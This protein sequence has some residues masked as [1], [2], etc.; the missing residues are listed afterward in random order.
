MK[1]SVWWIMSV[2]GVGAV[3]VLLPATVAAQQSIWTSSYGPN[4]FTVEWLRPEFS[5]EAD[6]SFLTSVTYLSGRAMVAKNLRLV[7]EIPLVY[8]DSEDDDA[9]L[10]VGNPYLGLE[11]GNLDTVW[12][13]V[14][15]RVPVVAND[16]FTTFFLGFLTDFDRLEAFVPEVLSVVALGNY[17]WQ[18]RSGFSARLRAGPVL[19]IDTSD[20]EF[21]E[22][23][24]ELFML[25]SLQ[26][27]YDTQRVRLGAGFTGR[28]IATEDDLDFNERTWHHVGLAIIGKFDGVQPGLHFKVPLDD[29]LDEALDFVFG[30]S[31]NVSIR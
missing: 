30:L 26:G 4:N 17:Q 29:E 10:N 5:D 16:D 9:E 31:L 23:N 13:E 1:P 8:F 7:G 22:D 3:L 25:Y 20:E 14:G 15:V 12:G 2:L 21:D 24:T 18:H 11:A 19:W 27:W 28:L 6:A